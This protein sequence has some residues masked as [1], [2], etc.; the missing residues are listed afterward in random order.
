MR[1]FLEFLHQTVPNQ[2]KEIPQYYRRALIASDVLLVVYY[3]VCFF[4]FPVFTSDDEMGEYGEDFSK[5]QRHFLEAAALARNNEKN[6]R[7]IVWGK[8]E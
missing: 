1:F 4:F 8:W 5:L 2:G 6:V 3:L 7:G